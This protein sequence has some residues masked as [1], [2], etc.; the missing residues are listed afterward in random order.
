MDTHFTSSS[1]IDKTSPGLIVFSF[2]SKLAVASPFKEVIFTSISPENCISGTAKIT[3]PPSLI[4]ISPSISKVSICSSPQ[5]HSPDSTSTIN[6]P[7]NTSDSERARK[8][9][10]DTDTKSSSFGITTFMPPTIVFSVNSSFF[11]SSL[12]VFQNKGLAFLSTD[13]LEYFCLLGSVYRQ[14]LLI[15]SILDG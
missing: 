15:T 3:S 1:S 6:S 7:A 4:L 10:E 9:I 11:S 8:L 2:S 14:E 5:L 12:F 13:S